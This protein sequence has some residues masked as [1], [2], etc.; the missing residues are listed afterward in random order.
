M[1]SICSMLVRLTE[2]PGVL[3]SRLSNSHSLQLEPCS[4][5]RSNMIR[6][7]K[8][9]DKSERCCEAQTTNIKLRFGP[10]SS[11]RILGRRLLENCRISASQLN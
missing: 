1:Y 4:M 2:G 5:H 10:S 3:Y 8:R 7:T 9:T 11:K 6:G